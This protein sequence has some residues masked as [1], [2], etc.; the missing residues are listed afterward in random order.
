L[1]LALLLAS[2]TAGYVF[3]RASRGRPVSAPPPAESAV[4]PLPPRVWST[5]RP[6]VPGFRRTSVRRSI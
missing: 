1:L 2:M 4:K 6:T 5:T 3:N